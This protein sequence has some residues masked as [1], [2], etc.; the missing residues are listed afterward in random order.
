MDEASGLLDPS[1]TTTL[2]AVSEEGGEVLKLL[3]TWEYG[4]PVLGLQEID[5]IRVGCS[6]LLAHRSCPR[7]VWRGRGCACESS[8]SIDRRMLSSARCCDGCWRSFRR[9]AWADV[10]VHERTF[11]LSTSSMTA[12]CARF[13]HAELSASQ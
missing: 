11:E 9:S 4:W 6:G 13:A 7:A 12:M 2:V 1:P 5:R 8:G 10:D 3:G